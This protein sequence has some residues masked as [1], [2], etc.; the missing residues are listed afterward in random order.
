MYEDTRDE[1]AGNKARLDMN[2]AVWPKSYVPAPPI[3]AFFSRGLTHKGGLNEHGQPNLI[4]EWGMDARDE[5]GRVKFMNPNDWE[6][7]W[8]CFILQR[9][10][11]PDFYDYNQWQQMRYDTELVDS[12]Y[13]DLLGEFPR[14]GRYL[15]LAPLA[16]MAEDGLPD[17][18]LPL[19][20]RVLDDIRKQ[21]GYGALKHDQALQSMAIHRERKRLKSQQALRKALDDYKENEAERR[22]SAIVRTLTSATVGPSINFPIK[23]TLDKTRGLYIP[24]GAS[25]DASITTV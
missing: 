5:R 4:V 25:H 6:L 13:A 14:Q 8:A 7:G 12:Q 16:T 2:R 3:P 1:I 19:S 20:S 15:F 22:K 10:A 23:S 21:V 11:S 9:W 24:E 18:P 17:E